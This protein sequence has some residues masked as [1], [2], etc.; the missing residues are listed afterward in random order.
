MLDVYLVLEKLPEDPDTRTTADGRPATKSAA[1]SR[2]GRMLAADSS[3]FT[4]SD[5]I[6]LAVT[7]A[8]AQTALVAA[9]IGRVVATMA[10][11]PQHAILSGHGDFLATAALGEAGLDIDRHQDADRS[12][13]D[14]Q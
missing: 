2:L 1:I 8:S 14:C 7:A 10:Q 5:A 12:R 3:E 4:E 13:S 9:A 6:E 11:R